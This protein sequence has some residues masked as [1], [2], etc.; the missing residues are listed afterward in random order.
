MNKIF[1]QVSDVVTDKPVSLIVDIRP[2]NW[3]Q[4]LLQQ[5]RLYPVKRTF[6]IGQS[7]FGNLI[8]ISKLLN[9]IDG[10]PLDFKD[11]SKLINRMHTI[12]EKDGRVFAGI[13]AI[14]IHN[15]KS[16]PPESLIEFIE[17]NFSAKDISNVTSIVIKQMDVM[18]FIPTIISLK[19]MSILQT[20]GHVPAENAAQKE[21]SL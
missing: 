3:W 11:P 21:V 4:K 7:T 16:E 1:D 12:I 5:L 10:M 19:S 13:I 9:A 17:Y 14:A 20:N 15:K 2:Q 8:R 18:G 6:Y